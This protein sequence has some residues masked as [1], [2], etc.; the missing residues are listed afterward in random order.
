MSKQEKMFA[1]IRRWEASGLNKA[2]FS[3]VNDIPINTFHYWCRKYQD[4]ATPSAPFVQLSDVAG[5][6]SP[7]REPRLRLELPDGTS[8]VVY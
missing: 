6:A 1:V 7:P 2:E 5:V 8:L 4:E 3:R